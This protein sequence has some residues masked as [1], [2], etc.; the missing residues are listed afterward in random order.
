MGSDSGDGSGE[1]DCDPCEKTIKFALS[2]YE[3]P[4]SRKRM[5]I[6]D[7]PGAWESCVISGRGLLSIQ[8]EIEKEQHSVYDISIRGEVAPPGT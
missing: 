6:Q 8:D 5:T 3:S 1:L 7:H 4:Y 2:G